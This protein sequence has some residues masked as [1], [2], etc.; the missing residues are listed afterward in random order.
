M[1]IFEHLK[2]VELAS[3]LAGPSVGFFFAELGAKVIKI[4]NQ[5]AGGDVTRSWKLASEDQSHPFSAYYSSVNYGKESWFLNLKEPAELNKVLEEIKTA[6]LVIANFKPG[7]ATKLGLSFEQ[8]KSLNSKLI[9]GEITGFGAAHR[10]A[11]DVVL[12][13]ESGFLAMNGTPEGELCKMPVALIDILAAHQLKEGILLAMLQQQTQK[14][15]LKVSVSLFDAALSALTNQATNWLM[16]NHIAQP[17]GT[18]HPNIAPYGELFTCKDGK[19]LVLAVGSNRQFKALCD[20]LEVPNFYSDS[21][22]ESNQNRVQNRLELAALLAT[23][24]SKW[25]RTEIMDRF[26]ENNVPAGAV[27]K[28]DEVFALEETQKHLLKEQKEGRTLTTVSGNAF[29]ITEE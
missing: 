26:I 10:I 22:F 7:D 14:K 8:I 19:K 5:K 25:N 4:E 29:K 17:M 12:Q 27:R 9:Y 18:L 21:R 28:M 20:T 13:A 2:V 24:L 1:K 6:D 3:V 16:A 23:Q 15:A 11:Y